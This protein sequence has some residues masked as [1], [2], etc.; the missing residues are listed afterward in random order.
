M[1]R[2]PMKRTSFGRKKPE[3]FS[4]P[5]DDGLVVTIERV[6]PR[7][8]RIPA[9]SVAVFRPSIKR[10][11]IRSPALL[12]ACRALDCQSCGGG[13][14]T[15][16]A[17]HSNWSIHGKGKGIKADDNRVAAMCWRCHTELDQGDVE[18]NGAKQAWWWDC[19]VKT[20]RHLVSG[21]QWPSGVPVPDIG[22]YPSQWAPA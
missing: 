12:I 15:V 21:G 2:T 10:Q 14:G 4:L 17:A 1:R 6:A 13:F 8:Y 19:H 7:L 5:V 18:T 11:Y 3:R 16:V 9:S 20:V 22:E